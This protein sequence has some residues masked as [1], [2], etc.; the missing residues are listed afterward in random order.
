MSEPL[1]EASRQGKTLREAVS[2]FW[3]GIDELGLLGT[4]RQIADKMVA[5]MDYI[6][7]DG[8]LMIGS[9]AANAAWNDG[10]IDGLVPELQKA[11]VLRNAYASRSEESRVGKE[12]VR[13]C[14][15]R[16]SPDTQKKKTQKNKEK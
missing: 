16:R 12:C 6:G 3:S 13:T 2:G 11:G 1:R 9:D 10:V 15:S 4:P 7:G 14:R 5:A 8:F